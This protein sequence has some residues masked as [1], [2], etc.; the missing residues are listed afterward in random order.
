MH[1]I[2]ECAIAHF[3]FLVCT[4]RIAALLG[5]GRL[6]ASRFWHSGLLSC[7]VRA[8]TGC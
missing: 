7:V 5:A 3:R 6:E 4:F 2:E 8:V 1:E